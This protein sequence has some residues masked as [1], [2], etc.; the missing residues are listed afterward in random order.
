M[1]PSASCQ[2]PSWATRSRIW[3]PLRAT[4]LTSP[5]GLGLHGP[6]RSAELYSCCS[7]TASRTSSATVEEPPLVQRESWYFWL[8]SFAFLK[9]LLSR[10]SSLF[11]KSQA[12]PLLS[13]V[14]TQ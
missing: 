13:L 5:R 3:A 1:G 4:P 6:G 11:L 7:A 14:I 12:M 9:T 2:R 10:E 8:G